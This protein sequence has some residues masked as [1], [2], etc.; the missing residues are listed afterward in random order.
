VLEGDR[1]GTYLG[2][3]DLARWAEFHR[4]VTAE[5]ERERERQQRER[6][7]EREREGERVSA[8]VSPGWATARTTGHLS[9]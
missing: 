4:K 8:S 6:E 3:V 5:R 9:L 2:E 7:R 1:V